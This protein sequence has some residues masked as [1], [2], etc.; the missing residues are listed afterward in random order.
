MNELDEKICQSF[1]VARRGHKIWKTI[2]DTYH[3]G[4]NDCLV[5]F[6]DDNEQLDILALRYLDDYLY[7]KYINR[8]FIV[9]PSEKN[10]CNSNHEMISLPINE[11]NELIAYY[12][13]VQFKEKLVVVSMMEPF[14]NDGII[15]KAGITLDDY[16]VNALYV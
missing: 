1:D 5:I 13:L 9:V 15:G 14:G 7:R 2:R 10:I 12:K 3:I 4:E 11:V 8:A 6:P 16:I